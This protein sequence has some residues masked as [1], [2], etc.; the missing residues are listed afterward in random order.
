MYLEGR[1]ES[2]VCEGYISS[3]GFGSLTWYACAQ[4]DKQDGRYRVLD[5]EGAAEIGG[6]ISDDGSDD[7]NHE[8]GYHKGNVAAANV[9]N[10]DDGYRVNPWTGKGYLPV[11]GTNAKRTFQKR[12][13]KWLT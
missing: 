8:Y 12:Q 7:A 13:T 6:G 5:V 1:W 2:G 4:G 10:R 11:G 9:C 3:G